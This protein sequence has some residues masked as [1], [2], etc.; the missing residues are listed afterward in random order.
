MTH[1][2]RIAFAAFALGFVLLVGACVTLTRPRSA[3]VDRGIR[4]NHALHAEKGLECSSCHEPAEEGRYAIASH[5]VC[6]VCHEINIEEPEPE[7][8]A[9]CHTR[10]NYEIDPLE[11]LL[12]GDLNFA[13][14]PHVDKEVACSV[15]HG[16][17]DTG[18]LAGVSKKPFCM[19]CHGKTD[20]KLNE[21]SVCHR[22]TSKDTV[23]LFRAGVRIH[24]D[25]PALWTRL[26]GSESKV[27]P[28]YCSLCHDMP[29]SCDTCHQTHAPA[30]HT[31]SWRRKTHGLEASWD[32]NACSVCHEE[33]SCMQCHTSTKPDSHRGAW[34]SPINQHCTSCHF[35]PTKTN[36]VVCHE[37]ID[38]KT[39]MP[40]PHRA[41]I[42]PPQCALCHPGGLPT[43]AP[44]VT[45]S[46]VSCRFCH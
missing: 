24:H 28:N 36:C 6:S 14:P 42:Y 27:N 44:H 40:S 45:N 2:R 16:N 13:H 15:C 33:D 43:R 11:R 17:P 18:I 39:A 4:V 41:L 12:G 37:N 23:P 35:P 20:Q 10:D 32:R 1:K 29:E 21:C 9:L 19:D 30:N 8:C 7:K 46:T 26:H 3:K 31:I 22:E 25:E 5:D 38:H 34:S